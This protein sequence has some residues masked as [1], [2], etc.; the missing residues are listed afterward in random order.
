MCFIV[1]FTRLKWPT[2]SVKK[3][4]SANFHVSFPVFT[5]P[6]G[7]EK[8]IATLNFLPANGS[9]LEWTEDGDY[10]IVSKGN[11]NLPRSYC[12]CTPVTNQ[13]GEDSGHRETASAEI[14]VRL[15][16]ILLRGGYVWGH[17]RGYDVG[18]CQT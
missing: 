9:R 8:T 17:V 2:L 6:D 11:K 16:Q 3:T 14:E 18:N 10:Y 15:I 4:I 12:N 7:Q 13:T 1:S 5:D